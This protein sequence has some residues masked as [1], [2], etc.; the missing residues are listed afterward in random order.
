VL[1]VQTELQVRVVVVP[2]THSAPH[3]GSSALEMPAAVKR[4]LGLDDERSWIVLD[5][6]N[7][8]NWPGPDLRPAG[9]ADTPVYG[10]LPVGFFRKIRDQ[11]VA[12]IRAGKTRQV[13][14]TK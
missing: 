11:L 7:V 5:E 13:P 12:N 8:F 9:G 10:L 6:I 4:H 2:I 14:R 3:S 1:T